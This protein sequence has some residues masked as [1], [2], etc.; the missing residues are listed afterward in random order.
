M[1]QRIDFTQTSQDGTKLRCYEWP[2]QD[3]RAAVVIVH[4]LAEHAL[5]YG[6]FALALNKAGIAAVSMD[7][8]G[9][10]TTS[11]G[12]AKG[13]F[14]KK[15][16]WKA[17][18]EDIRQLSLRAQEKY[19]GK[20][21]ILFGHSM[22]SI[23]A[24]AALFTFGELY[25][26]A[27]LSGVTVDV[28]GRRN[29]APLIAGIVSTLQ[30]KDKPSALL[31]NLTFG[32][33]NKRFKPPRTRFDWLSRDAKEVDKYVMDENCGF[34]CTGSMFVDVSRVLLET[35]KK[36]NI[37]RMPKAVP[38][39]IVSGALDPV[40]GFGEAARYLQKRYQAAGLNIEV[41]MY[42]DARHELLNELNRSKVTADLLEFINR[43]I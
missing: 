32:A 21:L 25:R 6:R 10:G 3:A 2:A 34:I 24:R 35:L 40:G 27:I 43:Q 26:A 29:V 12:T 7:L 28:P 31:D 14:S 15:D 17:V 38:L 41:K 5:R 33:Y 9:H 22:G 4:G 18:L 42:E 11:L 30:G 1:P 39:F 20:P 8:R 36:K 19:A 23:F 37:A 13:Q 16:G